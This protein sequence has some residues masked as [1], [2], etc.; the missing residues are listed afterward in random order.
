MFV[1]VDDV[2]LIGEDVIEINTVKDYLHH[3]FT[4]KD[5]GEALYFLGVKIARTENG[6]FLSQ[7]KY[8]IDILRDATMLE[9]FS[10]S[11]GLKLDDQSGPL[12]PDPEKYRRILGCLLYL[13]LTRPYIS[14]SVHQVSLF[15]QQPT[16]TLGCTYDT[17]T[18]LKG[19]PS[20][21]SLI[22]FQITAH[23]SSLL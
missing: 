15:L 21:G 12:L 19:N 14:F 17:I 13:N 9:E 22:F 16:T 4:I 11:K 18:L 2:L 5:I 1:Y 6:L 10:M 20:Q 7:H 23:P 8:I 3:A